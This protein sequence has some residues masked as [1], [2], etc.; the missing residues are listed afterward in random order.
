M[1]THKR[2]LVDRLRWE[3]SEHIG[4]ALFYWT[5]IFMSYNSNHMEGSTLS[6]AQTAQIF[7]TGSYLAETAGEQVNVDDPIETANH[8][9]AFN[10]ILDHC[11]EPVDKSMI[12]TL[13]AILKRGT[14]QSR[15]ERLNIGGYK[16]Q[17]N[18][19]LQVL[20]VSA[21]KTAPASAIPE[22]MEQVFAAYERLDDDPL[23][24]AQCH[25]MFE[26][27]HP[28]SDG[29]GRVGRL[30]MFKECLRLDCVP[31]LIRDENHNRYTSA[32][33]QYPKEPGWLVD[34]IGS[35]RDAYRSAFLENMAHDQISCTYHDAWQQSEYTKDLGEAAAFKR[36][37]EDLARS[38]D[39]QSNTDLF[40]MYGD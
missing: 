21:A 4:H 6:A 29:N 2:R 7:E 31:P 11:D 39:A 28:F 14:T 38:H 13:H 20:G 8:F 33:D 30:V 36:K 25:W 24:I 23:R 35:E 15:Q 18:E 37:I 19:I 34:L 40:G 17:D 32:L 26:K 5:Q 16:T 1:A 12:G 27:V 3:R 10:F 9:E 22:L